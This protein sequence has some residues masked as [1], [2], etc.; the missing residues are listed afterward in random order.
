MHQNDV[1]ANLNSDL[2][3]YLKDQNVFMERLLTMLNQGLVSND[4]REFARFKDALQELIIKH[5]FLRETLR[6]WRARMQGEPPAPQPVPEPRKCEPGPAAPPPQVKRV[7]WSSPAPAALPN[8]STGL[9]YWEQVREQEATWEDEMSSL[10]KI[11]EEEQPAALRDPM[12]AVSACVEHAIT[13]RNEPSPYMEQLLRRGSAIEATMVRVE[14]TAHRLDNLLKQSQAPHRSLTDSRSITERD[15]LWA[16]A[17]IRRD[18]GQKADAAQILQR[19]IQNEIK[20]I[21]GL[22][23]EL[24]N[25]NSCLCKH[26]HRS[27]F[28]DPD[29][30]RSC[31]SNFSETIQRTVELHELVRVRLSNSRVR[32]LSEPSAPQ[33]EPEPLQ[34]EAPKAGGVPVRPT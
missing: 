5:E 6:T 30:G 22:P 2:L 29:P 21:A 4:L 1:A 7:A 33:P 34:P 19:V 9:A 28:P 11:V 27:D 25:R 8:P 12:K 23:Q 24:R 16:L 18:G 14:R 15:M 17:T 10:L 32:V 31:P 26:S 13:R 3:S 20:L